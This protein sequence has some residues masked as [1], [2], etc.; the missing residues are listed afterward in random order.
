MLKILKGHGKFYP[1]WEFHP[2]SPITVLS[3]YN[4]PES[5]D[6]NSGLTWTRADLDRVLANDNTV[7]SE[8]KN[9]IQQLMPHIDNQAKS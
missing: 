4:L 2:G 5:P 3:L 9:E 8:T 1:G 7:D 6:S